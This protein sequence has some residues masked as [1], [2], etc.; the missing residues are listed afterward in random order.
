MFSG[1]ARKD[2]RIAHDPEPSGTAP[3]VLVMPSFASRVPGRSPEWKLH[4][5]LG[6]ARSA[7]SNSHWSYSGPGGVKEVW[8][9][10][11][12]GSWTQVD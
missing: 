9:R 5:G 10:H 1:M 3:P 8:Q 4:N 7:V 12:N 11:R 2:P 6:Q